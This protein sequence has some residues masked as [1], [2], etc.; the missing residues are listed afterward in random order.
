MKKIIL[1]FLTGLVLVMSA[2]QI[3]FFYY[4][5]FGFLAFLGMLLY[6]VL[7]LSVTIYL[8]ILIIRN[9]DRKTTKFRIICVL[10]T[11]MFGS[12]S[13]ILSLDYNITEKLEKWDWEYRLKD[14][15]KIV[16]DIKNGKKFKRDY[17]RFELEELYFPPISNYDN[18][19]SFDK[20]NDSIVTVKFYI[21]S[22]FLDHY[23]AFVYT[24]DTSTIRELEERAKFEKTK[25]NNKI[26]GNNWFR[27]SY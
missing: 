27:V 5:S 15:N 18:T 19:I 1:N 23:S 24:N 2:I 10:L 12:I 4:Y 21:D 6:Q 20:E 14:R 26:L 17:G 11:I 8:T 3:P 16:Q 13:V 7:G 22:G 25:E 9:K